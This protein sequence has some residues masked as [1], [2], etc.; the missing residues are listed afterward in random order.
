[1]EKSLRRIGMNSLNVW[2]NS[3]VKPSGSG[4]FFVRRF[5]IPDLV[6]LL[7]I[8]LFRFR[9]ITCHLDLDDIHLKLLLI[10]LSL[11]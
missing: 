9:P 4:H 11:I 2:Q 10:C 8:V 6:L 7:V 1:M 3:P 5:W